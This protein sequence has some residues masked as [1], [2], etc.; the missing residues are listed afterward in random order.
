[1]LPLCQE[2]GVPIVVNTDAHDPSAVGLMPY[3]RA[4]LEELRFP[5]E[6]VLN[7]DVE[8]ALAFLNRH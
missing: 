8:K 3:A 7:T 5:E 4:L 1:M 6:L 2:L